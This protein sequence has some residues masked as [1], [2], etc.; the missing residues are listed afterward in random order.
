MTKPRTIK[1][2]WGRGR[3]GSALI[4]TMFILAGMLIVAMSGVY[5]I[6]LG[7]KASGLQL[8]SA[9]AYYVGEAGAERLLWELRKDNC[10]FTAP[11]CTATPSA[12]TAVFTGTL[13]TG[14]N[15][16]VYYTGFPPL[17]FQSVGEYQNTRRSVEIRI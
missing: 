4:L 6:L 10:Q 12:S 11:Y 8:Q 13:S 16:Q 15:Y 14:L 9:K 3:Q 17:I 2:L 7:I 5:I 1:Q